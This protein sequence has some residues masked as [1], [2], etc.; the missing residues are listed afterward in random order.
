MAVV[1]FDYAEWALIYPTIAAHTPQPLAEAYFDIATTI[2]DNS[3]CAIIPYDPPEKTTRKTALYLLVAH[4]AT[5]NGPVQNG[6][7]GRVSSATQ[8]SVSVGLEY[9]VSKGAAWFTQTQ[10]GATYWQMVR[11]YMLGGVY[12]PGRQ[13]FRQPRPPGA[14]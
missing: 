3:P 14:V 4:I 7:V 5:L 1:V 9:N 12:H 6:S 11:P 2:C 8:G 10:W 13:P